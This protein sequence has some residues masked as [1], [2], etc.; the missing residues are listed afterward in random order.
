LVQSFEERLYIQRKFNMKFQSL[1]IK[2]F[3]RRGFWKKKSKN[4]LI[5]FVMVLWYDKNVNKK[6]KIFFIFLKTI[7]S[8]VM[9]FF[10]IVIVHN[11]DWHEKNIKCLVSLNLVEILFLRWFVLSN[12]DIILNVHNLLYIMKFVHFKV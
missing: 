12:V 11:I 1:T 10:I 8:I 9:I 7:N 2:Y 3:S 4:S 6:T 5:F